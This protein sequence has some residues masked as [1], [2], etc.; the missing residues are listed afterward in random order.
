MKV[1]AYD[2]YN[3]MLQNGWTVREAA[4]EFGMTEREIRQA[5]DLAGGRIVNG[6]A[7]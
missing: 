5:V 6:K 3:A 1:T 4:R 2:V 7:R